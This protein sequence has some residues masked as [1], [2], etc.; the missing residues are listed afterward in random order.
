[1]VDCEDCGIERG[2]WEVTIRKKFRRDY[3]KKTGLLCTGCLVH[4]I[5]GY[6][7]GGGI[8][9]TCIQKVTRKNTDDLEAE[10]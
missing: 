2:V 3:G 4:A 1:M 6:H 10:L 9:A 7:T 8:T 5:E